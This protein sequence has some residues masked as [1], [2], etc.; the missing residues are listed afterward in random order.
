MYD[1]PVRDDWI[2]RLRRRVARIAL[3]YPTDPLSLGLCVVGGLALV[4]LLLASAPWLLL[5]V[6]GLAVIAG[7]AGLR[8]A[9]GRLVQHAM[10]LMI[11]SATVVFWVAL[12]V[13]AFARHLVWWMAIL[14]LGVGISAAALYYWGVRMGLLW[15]ILQA[16]AALLAM[17]LA[18][19]VPG[20]DGPELTQTLIAGE[21]VILALHLGL[22]LFMPEQ[23]EAHA[24]TVAITRQSDELDNLTLQISATADGLGRASSA[25][26]MVTTQQGSGVEQ[27]AAVITQAVTMLSEFIALADQVRDQAR[28]V[29]D[30][31][32]QTASVSERG[33]HTIRRAIEGMMQIRTQVTVIAHN[34]AALAE[35]MQRI[36][37]IIASVSEI[38][39]Q[40]H[41]LALNAGIE[42]ARAGAQGRGFAVVANE[43]RTLAQQSKAAAAQV[44]SILSEIQEAMRQTVRATEVGD[45]QVDEGLVLSQQAGEVITQLAASVNESTEAVRNIMV[46][47]D[48][49]T[50]GLQ[51]IAQSMQNIQGIMQQNLESTRTAEIVAENLSRLSEELLSAIARHTGDDGRLEPQP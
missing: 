39:T 40:S 4:L 42:A 16:A 11:G 44:Q 31:S 34:I 8:I 47:I 12:V 50:V 27:Q 26:H 48:Q 25:I 35:Q 45:Q 38:A 22:L 41:L 29:V 36:D 6:A 2:T 49:Q 23:R 46:A 13:L 32:E 33:Q 17:G 3:H 15:G 14:P 43:I 7:L 51:Q 30:L 19:T 20:A 37:E 10:P 1:P 24:R 18:A 9:R 21:A 28:S 5:A